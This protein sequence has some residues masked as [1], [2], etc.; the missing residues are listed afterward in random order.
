MEVIHTNDYTIGFA[1]PIGTAD[2]YP[3]YGSEQ[4]G[5]SVVDFVVKGL[6]AHIRA[7]QLFSESIRNNQFQADKC[8]SFDDIINNNC[9]VESSGYHMGGD[10][11]NSNISGVFYLTTQGFPPFGRGKINLLGNFLF[12]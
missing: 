6:C 4:P 11:P 3:N 1:E 7:T 2:F 10:P 12:P 9:K 8:E 5:C